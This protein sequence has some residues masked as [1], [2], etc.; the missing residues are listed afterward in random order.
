MAM[1]D[2]SVPVDLLFGSEVPE[3]M[4]CP[5]TSGRGLRSPA[6]LPVVALPLMQVVAR[7]MKK[8]EAEAYYRHCLASGLCRPDVDG[9][10]FLREFR[11]KIRALRW[12]F[13][14]YRPV[15]AALEKDCLVVQDGLDLC[16]IAKALGK[17][18]MKVSMSEDIHAGNS[19]R[20]AAR[21]SI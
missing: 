17:I 18:W 10:S 13:S 9:P 5:A 3:V 15:V 21:K 14:T 2:L 16:C 7:A 12:G 1:H 20:G 19:V 8:G 11:R 4:S 6:A